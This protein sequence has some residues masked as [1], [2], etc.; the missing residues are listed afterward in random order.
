MNDMTHERIELAIARVTRQFGATA[1]PND[2][3]QERAWVFSDA[4]M[5]VQRYGLGTGPYGHAAMIV[6]PDGQHLLVYLREP[7]DIEPSIHRHGL[8]KKHLT[9]LEIEALSV[10]ERLTNWQKAK[11][12]QTDETDLL[13]ID[14][15]AIF[16]DYDRTPPHPCGTCDRSYHTPTFAQNCCSENAAAD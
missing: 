9:E 7:E 4:R 12:H 2:N 13:P 15:R 14:D 11:P 6:A 1:S 3:P 5:S 16:T 8:W 10:P